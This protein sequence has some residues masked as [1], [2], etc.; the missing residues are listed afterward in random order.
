MIYLKKKLKNVTI[1]SR[2][3][4]SSSINIINIISISISINIYY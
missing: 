1:I 3:S 2:G 4:S